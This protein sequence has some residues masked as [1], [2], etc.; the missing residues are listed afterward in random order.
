[1][2]SASVEEAG[3]AAEYAAGIGAGRALT[4]SESL[5]GLEDA[6]RETH[7]SRLSLEVDDGVQVPVTVGDYNAHLIV[8]ATQRIREY[9]ESE[10]SAVRPVYNFGGDSPWSGAGDW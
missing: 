1:M 6:F 5:S 3:A 7:P 9:R 8:E 4:G 2:A 10:K